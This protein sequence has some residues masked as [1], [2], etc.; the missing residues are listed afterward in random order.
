MK[1]LNWGFTVNDI[2]TDFF[3][4]QNFIINEEVK[5]K[6]LLHDDIL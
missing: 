4:D 3:G 5:E 6:Q 2:Y 1:L